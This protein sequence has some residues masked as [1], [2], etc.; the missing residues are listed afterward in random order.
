MKSPGKKA[1]LSKLVRSR[2]VK[3]AVKLIPHAGAAIHEWIYGTDSNSNAREVSN[4]SNGSVEDHPKLQAFLEVPLPKAVSRKQ[5]NEA[6]DSAMKALVILERQY[7]R[8]RLP[9]SNPFINRFDEESLER[10]FGLLH[11]FVRAYQKAIKLSLGYLA[12]HFVGEALRVRQLKLYE[13]YMKASVSHRTS[14]HGLCSITS[15]NGLVNQSF[16]TV[17]SALAGQLKLVNGASVV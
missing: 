17:R 11:R 7:R 5:L 13:F 8:H 12:K 9:N 15:N 1:K 4:A 16:G 6:Y 14:L 10:L 3:G 2:W